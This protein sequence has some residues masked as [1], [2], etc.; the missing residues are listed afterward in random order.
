MDGFGF[1]RLDLTSSGKRPLKSSGQRGN[2]PSVAVGCEEFIVRLSRYWLLR[3]DF[4]S[5]RHF[6]S[7]GFI[8]NLRRCRLLA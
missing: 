8:E 4:I 5:G 1:R 7:I 6:L 2:R 3:N